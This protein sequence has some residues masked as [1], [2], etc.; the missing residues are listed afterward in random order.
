MTSADELTDDAITG[1]YRVLQRRRGHR[2]SL[3]DLLTADEAVRA[4][5]GARRCLDLGCGLGSVLLMAAWRLP[6]ATFV[7]IEA[8]DVSFDLACRNVERNGLGAR[9]E[10][11]RGDLRDDARLEG[12][13]PFD[14]ITGTPPYFP[15]GTATPSPDPQRAA[16]RVELRG[17]VEDYLAT[18]GRLVAEDG[19]VVVCADARRPERVLDGAARAALT[20]VRR[21]DAIPRAGRDGALFTVWTLARR[22]ELSVAPP[23]VAR[24]VDGARTTQYVALRGAFGLP[25]RV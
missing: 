12:L 19:R 6:R 22:G 2:Y 1:S 20:P 23:F 17:G 8:Q 5:P 3:D 7:G 10:L 21:L 4:R 18:A 11:F 13:G 15:P 16:A 9:V 14:L 24:D 25:A